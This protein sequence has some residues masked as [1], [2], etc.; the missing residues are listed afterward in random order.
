[1]GVEKNEIEGPETPQVAP[2]V[3][4]VE[5][6]EA[7]AYFTS[8]PITH[9]IGAAEDAET[10]QHVLNTLED[11][12]GRTL[13]LTKHPPDDTAPIPNPKPTNFVSR[14]LS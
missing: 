11:A 7:G 9:E 2:K 1:M 14:R 3:V 13:D 8:N 12:N 5:I 6:V 10:G 4:N